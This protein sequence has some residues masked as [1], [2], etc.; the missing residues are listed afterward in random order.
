M[1]GKINTNSNVYGKAGRRI[2]EMLKEAG[3]ETSDQ[4]KTLVS[5]SH[6][7][8]Y[9]MPVKPIAVAFPKNKGQ[10]ATILRI[11]NKNR[12][13]VTAAGG[14]SSLTGSS[15]PL[16]GG[17]AISME[18]MN[19]I[20]EI[21]IEDG[22][23]RAE[24]N[25]TIEELN[26]KL[27]RYGYFY[28]PDPASAHMATIGGSISTNAGGLKALMY[29]STKHWVLDTE[30][31]LA[32]GEIIRTG[33][34]TLKMSRGY[35]LTALVCGSEGTLG[36]VTQATL[37]IAK[38]PE[39]SGITISYFNSIKDLAEA[40]GDLKK[41][42]MPLIM[43]EFMDRASLMEFMHARRKMTPKNANYVL[44]TSVSGTGKNDMTAKSCAKIIRKHK[45]VKQEY[46]RKDNEI[47]RIYSARREL[48]EKMVE[49]AHMEGKDIIIGDV[50]VPPSRLAPALL[51]IEREIKHSGQRVALFGHI[52]DGNI[53]SN[54]YFTPINK[55]GIRKVMKLQESI[56]RIALKNNGS[57]SAEHGIG[58][59][60]KALLIEELS[61]KDSERILSIM[62]EIK[63]AFDPNGILNPGKIFDI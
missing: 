44:L 37:K 2:A 20:I 55:N 46:I 63:K 45:P 7:K 52:G 1:P 56:G 21:N 9:I 26:K 38:K 58:L 32:S 25:V 43:A 12:I 30:L 19:R 40:V 27:E 41:H 8:S 39:S 53:H 42:G 23:A 49:E 36:I 16:S 6:D 31:V 51:E 62:K 50:I 15:I 4:G 29:G 34:S 57:V 13:K 5:F 33:S 24:P 14:G 17:I 60:K 10:V 3:I 47:K 18:R 35:D 59:E 61:S 11:C 48:H 54:V 28:L 22:F